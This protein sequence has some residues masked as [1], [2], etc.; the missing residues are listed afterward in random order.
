LSENNSKENAQIG[1]ITP[2]FGLILG[3]DPR[4]LEEGYINFP[5]LDIGTSILIR[6]RS[7]EA[8]R[9]IAP[10]RLGLI[11]GATGGLSKGISTLAT[12]VNRLFYTIENMDSD[13]AR[14]W[15]SV[16]VETYI[17]TLRSMADLLCCIIAHIS[18]LHGCIPDGSLNDMKKWITN[19]PGRAPENIKKLFSNDFRWFD[20]I[21]IMRDELEHHGAEVGIYEDTSGFFFTVTLGALKNVLNPDSELKEG[22]MPLPGKLISLTQDFFAFMEKA[23]EVCFIETTQHIYRG[24]DFKLYGTALT[25]TILGQF[26]VFIDGM[27]G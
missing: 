10:K 18:S 4:K 1:K 9:T 19:N 23:A 12:L 15:L 13:T 27:G 5:I 16:D 6:E 26:K 22:L 21:K 20:E 17:G 3:V 2:I 8:T 7:P 24:Q 11:G 14:F 25:G